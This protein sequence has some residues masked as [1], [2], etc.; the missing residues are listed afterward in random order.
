M[1]LGIDI[2]NT[3]T[4]YFLY[5]NGKLIEKIFTFE[6]IPW[7]KIRKAAVVRTGTPGKALENR[8]KNA[9]FPVLYVNQNIRL[10]FHIDYR[11]DTLGA[12]RIALTAGAKEIFGNNVLVIDAGTC[13]TY[14]YLDPLGTYK[15]GSISPGIRMRYKALH[16]FTKGLPLL[17]FDNLVPPLTG[18]STEQSVHSGVIHGILKEIEGIIT[19]YRAQ[20]PGVKVVLSGGDADFLSESLKI[21]IF[22][23]QKFLLAQGIKSILSL[24]T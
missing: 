8:L 14:D 13:I 7:E 12:D 9:T 19:A 16:H 21:K 23:I 1:Q 10:P 3:R 2:G 22:A 17:T 20:Y 15:G 4:K 18:N 24:N 6:S 5:D 11:S